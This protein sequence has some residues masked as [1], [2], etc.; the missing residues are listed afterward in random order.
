MSLTYSG[1]PVG[2]RNAPLAQVTIDLDAIA[3]NTR[4]VRH[5]AGGAG[6][7][8]V[9]KADGYGHGAVEVA[10]TVLDHG[11]SW[12]AV[13][14]PAEALELRAAGIDAP[15]LL[16][17]YLPDE[18]FVD[19]LRA[20]VAI[21]ASSVD[22]LEAVAAAARALGTVAGVHL[23]A[24]TGMS[25]GGATAGEWPGLVAS[26]RRLEKTEAL[27][28]D[29]LWSHLAT[30]EDFDADGVH[31]QADAFT[32]FQR[33]ARDAG[34]RPRH[35]HLANSA[36]TFRLPHSHHTMVRVGTALY[37]IEPV[38]GSIFGL[39]S[40]MTVAATVLH[41]WRV[42]AGTPVS[43]GW[44]EVTDRE[45]TLAQVP[46]GYA[47]GL[48]RTVS[49]RQARLLVRGVQRP[50]VGRITMDQVVLDVGDLPVHPGDTA[51]MFGPGADGEPTAADWASWAGTNV[52]D[53]ITGIGPRVH[54]HYRRASART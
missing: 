13:T 15:I 2:T 31:L 25:R 28:I 9:V 14:S 38:H 21:G 24:D 4:L 33:V 47:D 8:A 37:G 34:L 50:I 19:V 43:Y 39:R 36:A 53:I 49:G 5:V 20:D 18:S 42:P 26:A 40:A 6:I 54:R 22:A 16:W 17:L 1:T 44:D 10:R 27:R 52:Q 11:A 45:T 46:L 35:L 41:T 3:H 12:L 51:V 29:G 32:A 30:V 48:P 23:E 7:M